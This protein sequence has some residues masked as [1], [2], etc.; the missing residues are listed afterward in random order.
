MHEASAEQ[1]SRTVI[2]FLEAVAAGDVD[3]AFSAHVADDFHHHNPW[4]A[5]DRAALCEAMK[6]SAAAEPGKCFEVQQVITEG[7]RVMVFS[8]PAR[9]QGQVYALVHIARL[10]D[11]RVAEMW[12]IGQ[13]VPAES[14]NALGMF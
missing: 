3:T 7:D 2:A 6:A 1:A 11:G 9:P 8:R 5:D 10:R 4:F 14:P 13:E 12:D